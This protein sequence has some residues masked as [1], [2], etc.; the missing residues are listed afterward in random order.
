MSDTGEG[1]LYEPLKPPFEN[2]TADNRGPIV[3][4]TAATI[5]VIT[6]LTVG[7]KLWTRLATVRSMGPNDIAIVAAMVCLTI[8]TRIFLRRQISLYL[9][10]VCAVGQTICIGLAADKGLGR[11]IDAIPAVDIASLSKVKYSW[12]YNHRKVQLTI[13]RSFTPRT[14]F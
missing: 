14:F 6:G 4:A 10:Q 3:L 5:I 2:L 8:K 9:V 13:W 7:V 12:S 11:H 1:D